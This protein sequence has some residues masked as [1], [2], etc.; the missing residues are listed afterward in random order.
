MLQKVHCTEQKYLSKK[1]IHFKHSDKHDEKNIDGY[2]GFKVK[3]KSRMNYFVPIFINVLQKGLKSE[4]FYL[5]YLC[6][7]RLMIMTLSPKFHWM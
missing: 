3:K 2:I 5:S 4:Y 7:L 6:R 1:E